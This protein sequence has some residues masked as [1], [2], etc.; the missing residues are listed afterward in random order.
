MENHHVVYLF[1]ILKYGWRWYDLVH[2]GTDGSTKR[3][4]YT[5]YAVWRKMSIKHPDYVEV[6]VEKDTYA[7]HGVHKGMQGVI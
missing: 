7:K 1:F 2:H 3:S 5:E 4:K 6:T